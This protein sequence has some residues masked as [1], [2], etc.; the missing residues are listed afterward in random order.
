MNRTPFV[1]AAKP[2]ATAIGANA[3]S[4][5]GE[6]ATMGFHVDPTVTGKQVSARFDADTKLPGVLVVDGDRLL[7]MISRERFLEHMSQPFGLEVYL[8]RPIAVL[9]KAI[10]ERP[11]VIA[12]H[13]GAHEAAAEALG[14]DSKSVWEPICVAFADGTYGMLDMHELLLAQSK[15]LA[16]ANEVIQ[17]QKAKA[18][19]A[20]RAKSQFLANMSHEIR[21]P[22]NGIIGMTSLV[23]DSELN[24]QQ[25]E[26]LT[27]VRGSADW[28]LGIIND[29][30]DFSKIEAGKLE[31]ESIPFD[32]KTVLRE[33]TTPLRVRAQEKGLQLFVDMNEDVP[34]HVAGDPV[35]L[36]Q[37]LVNLVGNAIKFTDGGSVTIRV[38]RDDQQTSADSGQLLW[39]V[40]DTGIGIPPERQADIFEEFEQADGSTTRQHGGTGLG[41]A[42]SARLVEL[43]G[44]RIRLESKVNHG[45]TFSFS[46]ALPAVDAPIGQIEPRRT[47]SSINR[48]LRI[49]L[50]EDNLVNQRLATALLQKA[51][52]EVALAGDGQAALDALQNGTFDVVL[53]DVQM[54]IMDGFEATRRIR[55]SR[56]DLADDSHRCDDCPRIEGRS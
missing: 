1:A 6:L 23:L 13:V 56:T 10:R 49:L 12:A 45:S 3:N 39:K 18:D 38:E 22:M 47:Q 37:V 50:A 14:R 9:L 43:M 8:Q 16:D 21:T 53:M 42:I 7:G 51:G 34:E 2:S 55:A 26:Y 36:R 41:L 52:H 11:L 17:L 33:V 15:L 19:E 27:M 25:R 4:A 44:G 30:L 29:V 54:P 31:L 46:I 24:E 5:I 40:T 28:L 48:Q 35:R 20:N 32:L